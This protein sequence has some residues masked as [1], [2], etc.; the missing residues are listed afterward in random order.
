[1]TVG[2][3]TKTIGKAQFVYGVPENVEILDAKWCILSMY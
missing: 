2:S 3:K 1:M